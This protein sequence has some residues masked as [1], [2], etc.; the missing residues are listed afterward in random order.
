MSPPLNYREITPAASGMAS[1]FLINKS[2]SFGLIGVTNPTV[3]V[4][5]YASMLNDSCYAY[6]D[7]LITF[8][9]NRLIIDHNSIRICG[10][11]QQK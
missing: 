2:F 11:F 9:G 4:P 10:E 1:P 7:Y 6:I 3:Q 5:I 8:V